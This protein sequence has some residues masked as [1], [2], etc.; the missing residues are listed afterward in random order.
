M[1]VPT[2]AS[3]LPNSHRGLR[4]VQEVDGELL[5]LL[6]HPFLCTRR[7][8]RSNL[9][10]VESNLNLQGAPQVD[11]RKLKPLVL[12]FLHLEGPQGIYLPVSF[13]TTIK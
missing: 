6:Q 4:N 12:S 10:H 5:V 13:S 11:L 2:G 3:I 8:G 9:R 1:S 7:G